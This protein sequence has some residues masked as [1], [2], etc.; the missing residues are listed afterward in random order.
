MNTSYTS[1]PDELFPYSVS[2]SDD[3]AD[4]GEDDSHVLFP[5]NAGEDEGKDARNV[6]SS[7]ELFPWSG[8]GSD[9]EGDAESAEDSHEEVVCV[10]VVCGWCT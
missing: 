8:G 1:R 10:W 5:Y 2:G 4:E 6:P 3:D 9:D 7:D